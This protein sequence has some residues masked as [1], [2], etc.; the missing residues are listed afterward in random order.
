MS[1]P[2]EL[3]RWATDGGADV[4]EPGSG[5]KDAGYG[6]A[7]APDAGELNWMLNRIY[8]WEVWL[9]AFESTAHTWSAAQT[10]N[11]AVSFG[12]TGTSVVFVDGFHSEGTAQFDVNVL[13]GTDLDVTG[14][15][16]LGG[17]LTLATTLDVTG[18]STFHGNTVF[19]GTGHAHQHAFQGDVTISG[20]LLAKIHCDFTDPVSTLAIA[21]TLQPIVTVKAAAFFSCN[22]TTTPT[23]NDGH[24]VA[25][26]AQHA[27]NGLVTITFATAFAN[28]FFQ[29]ALGS[30]CAQSTGANPVIMVEATDP[31]LGT[32]RTT[33]TM[34]FFF[35]NAT[36]GAI[37]NT[38]ACGGNTFRGSL[39]VTG[40]Q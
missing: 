34:S 6:D 11:A 5:T 7:A 4:V 27:T 9:N 37:Y 20:D 36:T 25:S 31:L 38:S 12:V 26:I 39:H 33:T 32:L 21:N 35:V 40:R 13:I 16:T 28:L 29:A 17:A 8:L 19:G 23:Y 10:F 14:D 2:T 18:V 3:T 30:V 15:L 22:G 24:G 1:K